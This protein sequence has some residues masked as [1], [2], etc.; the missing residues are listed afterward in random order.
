MNSDQPELAAYIG[1]DW[2]D[3]RHAVCLHVAAT[4]EIRSY[5]VEQKPEKLHE[6]VAS[7]RLE[8]GDRKVGIAIETSRGGL[9]YALMAY[10][11]LILYPINPKALANYR[12]SVSVSGAKDDPSDAALL[13]DLIYRHR[14]RC[15]P[16]MPDTPATRKIQLLCEYRRRVVDDQTA[17]TNRLEALLKDYFPQALE[18]AGALDT[19][20]ACDFLTK[21]PSLQSVQKAK[22][23][24]L[25]KFYLDHGCRR[26]ELI[27][28]RLDEIR[29]ARF[30]TEDEAA[31]GACVVVVKAIT[32]CLRP[33]I[34]SIK[35]FNQELEAAFQQHPDHELFE[36][37]PAAG[38]VMAPRLLAAMG[39]DRSR[40][41]TAV[42]IQQ[43]SG[44]APV[45]KK[46]GKMHYVHRRYACP[47]FVRQTF[48]EW[49]RLTI[50]FSGWARAYYEHQRARGKRHHA[51]IRALAYKWIR[52]IFRCWKDGAHYDEQI[53][54]AS[55]ERT[56]PDWAVQA[57]LIKKV[58]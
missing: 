41:E 46:S 15:R 44:I 1:L 58:A 11:F 32:G 29:H 2:A 51:A 9:I 33:V 23:A 17:Q 35:D 4:N 22:P 14:D 31:I 7:L 39:S 54:L 37:F 57:G 5:S 13:L 40:F 16:W 53:Y 55:L 56:K 19:V 10:D 20:Q 28:K 45:T 42:E 36:S 3:E 18:W 24:Q 21:W 34:A 27:E 30:L 12:E 49:A 43:F 6:W 26:A 8:F 25:R 50:G 52:I 48:H 38:K 47:R